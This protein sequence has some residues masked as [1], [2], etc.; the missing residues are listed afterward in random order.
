MITIPDSLAEQL[1]CEFAQAC[2]E[3]VEARHRRRLKDTPAHRAAVAEWQTQIDQLLDMFLATAV[4]RP[5]AGKESAAD[6]ETVGI[7]T[8][9]ASPPPMTTAEVPSVTEARNAV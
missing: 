4:D 2:A 1:S 9:R 5:A 3:L 8:L 7:G 6:I